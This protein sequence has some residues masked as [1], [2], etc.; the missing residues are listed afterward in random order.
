[1]TP[2]TTPRQRELNREPQKA[3]A[4]LQGDESQSTETPIK[5]NETTLP[6]LETGTQ[7]SEADHCALDCLTDTLI[8]RRSRLN[9][10]TS[11]PLSGPETAPLVTNTEG[12]IVKADSPTK[13]A[14]C[15]ADASQH[16]SSRARCL[17]ESDFSEQARS[18]DAQYGGR[19]A[20]NLVESPLDERLI[21]L[22]TSS[23]DIALSPAQGRLLASHL[24]A[25]ATVLEGRS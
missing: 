10:S 8:G 22:R 5:R 6:I 17:I 9:E 24:G 19:I 12:A 1:M 7:L 18:F 2:K 4:S 3:T 16:L 14:L 21:S 25:L 23:D 15:N 11:G 20:L 13:P